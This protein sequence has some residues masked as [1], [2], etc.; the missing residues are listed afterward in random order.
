[1]AITYEWDCKTLETYPTKADNN[2][3]QSTQNDVIHTV[4]WRLTGRKNYYSRTLEE[5]LIGVYNMEI[6]DL[7]HF[8][9]FSEIK[10]ED[11]IKWVEDGLGETAVDELKERIKE[12]IN[13]QIKPESVVKYLD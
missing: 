3:P 10:H 8:T 4:H 2:T 11:V 5:T 1:M 9:A 12:N 7:S 6:T 13:N